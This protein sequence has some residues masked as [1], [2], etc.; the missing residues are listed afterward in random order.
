MLWTVPHKRVAVKRRSRHPELKVRL[1]QLMHNTRAGVL[2][3]I[4]G[5]HSG[6]RIAGPSSLTFLTLGVRWWKGTST[7]VESSLFTADCRLRGPTRIKEMM[8]P[9]PLHLH[10]IS[11]NALLPPG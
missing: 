9:C 1:H 5:R 10:L 3:L 7:V 4:S 11:L 6:M 8:Q 2:S